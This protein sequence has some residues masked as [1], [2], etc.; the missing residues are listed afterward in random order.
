M[1]EALQPGTPE[2]D[3]AM[4]AKAEGAAAPEST[5]PSNETP[6]TSEET[7][8][9]ANKFQSV[10]DLEKAYLEAQK[11]ISSGQHK[12]PQAANTE[13]TPPTTDLPERPEASD[14]SAED[15]GGI[16][17]EKY[18]RSIAENGALTDEDYTELEAKGLPR[19]VVDAYVAGLQTQAQAR[20]NAVAEA[21][22][23]EETF[24]AVRQWASSNLSDDE[25]A[26]VQSQLQNA[27][28]EAEVILTYQT[29]QTRYNQANPGEASLVTGK[30]SSTPSA[31]PYGNKQELTEAMA[32][33]RYQVDSAYTKEVEERLMATDW[34]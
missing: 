13:E 2:Y 14:E 1:S 12:E 21:L 8:K 29:L 27:K 7:P 10:E 17:F 20:V 33:K 19:G 9:Y 31:R 3:A 15:S 11:L 18:S 30:T 22:G 16:D 4:V 24:E 32:D 6:E 28:S 26:A 25:F 5:P 23:G 34:V